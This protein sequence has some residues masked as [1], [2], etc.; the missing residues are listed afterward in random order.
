MKYYALA[1][2][3]GLTIGTIAAQTITLTPAQTATVAAGGTVS[4][5]VVGTAPVVTPPPP[6]PPAGTFWVYYGGKMAW[7]TNSSPNDWSWCGS[8]NYNDTSG[9]PESGAADIKFTLTCANGGWLPY[10]NGRSFNTAPYTAFTFALKPT[11]A[12]QAWNVYFESVNDTTDG[13]SVSVPDGTYCSP[14]F[15]VGTWYTCT[16]PLSAF[17]LSNKTI[18][19]FAIHDQT[20]NGSG[21]WEIDNVG[22][23]P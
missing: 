22:F 16:F 1:I 5:N 21:T 11:A 4:I 12:G 6:P 17:Q 7:G 10:A 2:I 18:L 13:I 20:G 3:C 9:N 23:V 15:A 19:K 14:A 8:A